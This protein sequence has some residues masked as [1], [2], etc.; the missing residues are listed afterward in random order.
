[1]IVS[2]S[3]RFVFVHLMKT[4]GTALTMALKPLLAESDIV[5]MGDPYPGL[6]KHSP[7]AEIEGVLGKELTDDYFWFSLIRDPLDHICSLYNFTGFF[8]RRWADRREMAVAQIPE[9]LARHPEEAKQARLFGFPNAR[10]FCTCEGFSSFIRSEFLRSGVGYTSQLVALRSKS[11]GKMRCRV[12]RLEER[13]S[14]LPELR[15]AIG[16]D[17]EFPRRNVSGVTLIERHDI[18]AEDVA[19]LKDLYADDIAAFGY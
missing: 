7:V 12:F 3:R 11:D 10:A 17:F 1:M 14:W 9:Y 16:M 8:V 2:H 13:D 19:Y 15:R 6:R 5:V 4:G 18:S